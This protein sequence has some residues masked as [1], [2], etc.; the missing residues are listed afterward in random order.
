VSLVKSL[1]SFSNLLY[2]HSY[3]L[4]N[5]LLCYS[6]ILIGFL[7]IVIFCTE[8]STFVWS[9]DATLGSMLKTTLLFWLKIFL[10]DRS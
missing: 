3:L 10:E 9:F 7:H 5:F 8:N 4:K 2:E 6:S 1:Q